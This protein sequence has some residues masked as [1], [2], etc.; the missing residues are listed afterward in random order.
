MS[1]PIKKKKVFDTG[2]IPSGIRNRL[3]R[4]GPLDLAQGEIDLNGIFGDQIAYSCVLENAYPTTLNEIA[5]NNE[6][7]EVV[8]VSVQLSYKDWRSEQ[9]DISSGLVEGLAGELIRRV[10]R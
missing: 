10:L 5:L 9:G 8:E 4:I 1:F 2:R 7:Q 6:T 3:P